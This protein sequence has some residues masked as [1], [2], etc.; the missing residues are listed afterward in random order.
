MIFARYL[1]QSASVCPGW[2]SWVALRLQRVPGVAHCGNGTV[3]LGGSQRPPLGVEMADGIG[4]TVRR[5]TMM[6]QLMPRT[7]PRAPPCGRS[8]YIET[9]RATSLRSCTAHGSADRGLFHGGAEPVPDRGRVCDGGNTDT[10]CDR[11]TARAAAAARRSP[12]VSTRRSSRRPGPDRD[13]RRGHVRWCTRRG[14]CPVGP[15]RR[16]RQPPRRQG[17]SSPP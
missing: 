3:V 9:S 7:M 10:Y 2:R 5:S 4:G 15:R 17:S 14:W 16:P 6:G 1:R 11:A 8:P 12:V 13:R